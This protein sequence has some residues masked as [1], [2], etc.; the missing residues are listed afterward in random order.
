MS[1]PNQRPDVGFLGD[2]RCFHV[3]AGKRCTRY[4]EGANAER[5]AIVAFLRRF[6]LGTFADGQL[7]NLAADAIDRGDHL[8]PEAPSVDQRDSREK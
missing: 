3:D 7:T 4:V 8:R 1:D 5:A 6:T 2:A